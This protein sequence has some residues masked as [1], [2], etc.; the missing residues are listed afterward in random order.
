MKSERKTLLPA[1]VGMALAITGGLSQPAWAEL[2]PCYDLDPPPDCFPHEDEVPG[3]PTNLTA[4]ATAKKGIDLSWMRPRAA[5]GGPV[6]NYVVYRATTPGQDVSQMQ[7]IASPYDT[8][9]SDTALNPATTYYYKVIAQNVNGDSP[10]SNEASATTLPPNPPGP[11]RDLAAT[12]AACNQVNLSWQPPASGSAVSSYA[13]YRSTSPGFATST[14]TLLSTTAATTYSD[15]TVSDR[16]TYY[17]K[18]TGKNDDG[19]G[20]PSNEAQATTPNNAYLS[21]GSLSCSAISCREMELNWESVRSRAPGFYRIY[22]SA[23]SGF[24]LHPDLVVGIAYT[25]TYR[26]KGLNAGTTYYYR[27]AFVQKSNQREGLPSDEA[28]ATTPLATEVNYTYSGAYGGPHALTSDGTR[29]FRYDLNGNLTQRDKAGKDSVY[30][31]YVQGNLLRSVRKGATT[32]AVYTYDMNGQRIMKEENGVKTRF[33]NGFEKI[34]NGNRFSYTAGSMRL[35]EEE[36]GGRVRFYHPDHLGS[37]NLLTDLHGQV[38]SQTEYYP[39]GATEKEWNDEGQSKPHYLYT[40]QYR[41]EESNL[42]YYGAR[43]Y[44]AALG[45]FTTADTVVPDPANPQHLNRYAYVNN[46]PMKY[47]DPSGHAAEDTPASNIFEEPQEGRNRS[48][49]PDSKVGEIFPSSPLVLDDPVDFKGI[50]V[51]ISSSTNTSNQIAYEIGYSMRYDYNLKVMWLLGDDATVENLQKISK[52]RHLE[53]VFI[54]TEG[55]VGLLHFKDKDLTGNEFTEMFKNNFFVKTVAINACWAGNTSKTR[56]NFLF[57]ASHNTISLK[58]IVLNSM[59]DWPRLSLDEKAI[60]IAF[61]SDAILSGWSGSMYRARWQPHLITAVEKL[62][63]SSDIIDEELQE[64]RDLVASVSAS[65]LIP[66]Q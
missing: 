61:Q 3:I 20:A 45:R 37:A 46:N 11:P 40:D 66:K 18:V 64:L 58:G 31:R 60:L 19:E 22:R 36:A 7:K 26:D 63:V 54:S 65:Q 42:Y 59:P 52:L 47:V 35:A 5:S 32:V 53:K 25:N 12:A 14:A 34:G 24:A 62:A 17:Y 44:D 56:G 39:F 1:L 43:Y 10:A 57:T 4:K 23:S 27:V 51:V 6:N 15:L 55:Q 38:I 8:A 50:G 9:Y 21:V 41:D 48:F 49:V 30:Y 33:F 28:N 2:D 29:T 16:T 13:I